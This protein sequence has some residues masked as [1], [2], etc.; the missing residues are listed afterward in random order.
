MRSRGV[1]RSPVETCSGRRDDAACGD[2]QAHPTWIV[3][4]RVGLV[5]RIDCELVNE[6]GK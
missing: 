1:H 4:A 5:R 3:L 2:M 6:N